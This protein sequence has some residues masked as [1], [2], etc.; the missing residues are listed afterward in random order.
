MVANLVKGLSFSI[1]IYKHIEKCALAGFDIF[2]PI[3]V[4]QLVVA[5]QNTL[6]FNFDFISIA[7]SRHPHV[8]VLLPTCRA[9]FFESQKLAYLISPLF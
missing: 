9:I 5:H 8:E 6:Q 1:C 3:T 2:R 7:D 4:F